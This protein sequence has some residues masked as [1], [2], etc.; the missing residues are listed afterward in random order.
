MRV[1]ETDHWQCSLPE[2]WSAEQE[3]ETITITDIDGVGSLEI[4]ALKKSA[5]QVSVEELQHFAKELID[6]AMVPESVKAGLAVGI[7]ATLC[8]LLLAGIA[9]RQRR[10]IK[11]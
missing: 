3:E 6:L 10:E 5:G 4:T 8:S 7:A 11:L 1:L 2:E 9:I